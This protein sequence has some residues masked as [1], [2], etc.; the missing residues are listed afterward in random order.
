MQAYKE[1]MVLGGEPPARGSIEGGRATPVPNP[2][3]LDGKSHRIH[4]IPVNLEQD[5]PLFA[6]V[7]EIP[8][9]VGLGLVIGNIPRYKTHL[10]E[11]DAGPLEIPG[12]HQKIHVRHHAPIFVGRIDSG[13]QM[14]PLEGRHI[15][16]PARRHLAVPA[17]MVKQND[18]LWIQI[19]KRNST[20]V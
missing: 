15:D 7:E 9:L 13:Q 5:A 16:S 18:I 1:K 11:Q 6:Q 4:Q 17:K 2:L 20:R 12:S 10:F 19:H 8:R 3:V 14:G